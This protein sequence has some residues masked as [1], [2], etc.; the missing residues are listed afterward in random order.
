MIYTAGVEHNEFTRQ[1]K[2][3][4][5][6]GNF[7][8]VKKK[9]GV[10]PFFCVVSPFFLTVVSP[11]SSVKGIERARRVPSRNARVRSPLCA[12]TIIV[13]SEKDSFKEGTAASVIPHPRRLTLAPLFLNV[14][15]CR[16]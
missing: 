14:S 7:Q 5:E 16:I 12:A 1:I 4:R 13:P 9:T 2:R 10:A 11:S 8:N 15:L 3:A 6:V